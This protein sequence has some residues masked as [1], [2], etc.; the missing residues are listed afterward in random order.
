MSISRKSKKKYAIWCLLLIW[1]LLLM[2][3]MGKSVAIAT[4]LGLIIVLFV[5][6]YINVSQSKNRH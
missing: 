6:G 3:P 2:S 5:L 4:I 1:L